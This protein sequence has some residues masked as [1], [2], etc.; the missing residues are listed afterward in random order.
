MLRS[1]T[2]ISAATLLLAPF[3]LAQPDSAD[4]KARA[5]AARDL[6]KQGS[7]ALPWLERL[8]LDNDLQVRIEAVKA[9]G[10]VGT[11][12]SLDPLLRACGD[13]DAEMQVRA[14]DGLVNFYLP[15]YLKNGFSGRM[16]RMGTSIQGKFTD[17]NDD[18]VPGYIEAR[19]DVVLAL[20][21]LVKV[22]AAV[23]V[24]ANAARAIGV[25]R[26]RAALP[27]LYDG[28]LTKNDAILYESLVAIKKIG[29][30][31][32]APRV[33]FLVK[34]LDERVQTVAAET[35][36]ILGYKPAVRDLEEVMKRDRGVKVKRATLTGLALLAEPSSRQFFTQHLNDKD[37]GLRSAA[38]EGLGRLKNPLDTP[39]LEKGFGNERKGAA[40]L[41]FAFALVLHGRKA[42]ESPANFSPLRL[43][44]NGL[45]TVSLQNVAQPFLVELARDGA[46]R[47]ELNRTLLNWVKAEKIGLAAVLGVSGDRESQTALEALV[48]DADADVSV[49]ATRALRVLRARLP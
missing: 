41:S 24:K 3:A 42:L 28:V 26:G 31:E 47:A 14:T 33:A 23:E 19:R 29:D 10:E 36:G 32:A 17:T 2:L 20:G 15:G 1:L 25:L 7:D 8:V 13:P 11:P 16:K 46:V 45:A 22:G 48:K 21:R 39:A 43:I 40:R 9:L 38:A 44:V 34:D 4:P 49:E 35:M 27:D 12:R 30:R 6:A 5:K 37:E 18:V